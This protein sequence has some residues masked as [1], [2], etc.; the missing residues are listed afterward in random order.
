MRFT[1]CIILIFGEWYELAVYLCIEYRCDAISLRNALVYGPAFGKPSVR[2][3]YATVI[4][5][6]R[7]RPVLVVQTINSFGVSHF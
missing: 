7:V 4:I 1:V 5:F 2:S 6:G 3:R